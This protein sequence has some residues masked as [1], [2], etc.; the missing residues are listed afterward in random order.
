MHAQPAKSAMDSV[1]LKDWTPDSSLVVPVTDIPK[2]R[3]P[4]IDVH[5][6]VGRSGTGLSGGDTAESLAAWMSV[7]DAVGLEKLIVLTEAT[8]TEFDR[9]L[10]FTGRSLLTASGFGAVWTIAI[11]RTRTIR[12][13]P[14][15]NWSVAI[16][17]APAA[18]VS[19]RIKA[20]AS[21]AVWMRL[22]GTLP[23]FR[24]SAACIL[25]I[26]GWICSGRNAAS[27]KSR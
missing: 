1:L 25:T 16:A 23:P 27:S 26:L 10:S 2:A 11:S 24:L 21:W 9:L 8:G 15:R 18:W 17:R 22:T 19:Y 12:N 3:Y 14:P 7:M 4:A 5:I 13:A 20:S 6:H